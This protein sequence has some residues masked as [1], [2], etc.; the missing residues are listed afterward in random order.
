MTG[1][2]LIVFDLDGTLTLD[3]HRRHFVTG[4]HKDYAEY[5]GQCV[6]DRPNWPVVRNMEVHA[7][8][9]DRVEIWT[10]RCASV[11]DLTVQWFIKHGIT[12]PPAL[13][14]R[15]IGDHRPATE[16]KEELLIS[17]RAATGVI[18]HLVY[19]DREDSIDM[20]L[21]HCV[22]CVHV[23][24]GSARWFERNMEVAHSSR[25]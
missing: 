13:H 7:K 8:A 19:E 14:M 16:L 10:G 23:R 15:A 12:V 5:Y 3:G 25:A 11:R 17:E 21:A 18:P 1:K 24:V 22:T 20:Y 6:Y 9:G 2:L 4:A